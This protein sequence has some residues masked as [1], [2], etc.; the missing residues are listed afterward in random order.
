MHFFISI[1]LYMLLRKYLIGS[2]NCKLFIQKHLPFL[3]LIISYTKGVLNEHLLN[4]WKKKN[5]GTFFLF[6][7][8][9]YYIWHNIFLCRSWPHVMLNSPS[10]MTGSLGTWT[11]KLSTSEW[12]KQSMIGGVGSDVRTVQIRV[13][14]LG[15]LRGKKLNQNSLKASMFL[16]T[17]MVRKERKKRR[18]YHNC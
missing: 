1:A 15:S 5:N 16:L 11:S 3:F 8:W 10:S 2:W 6:D 12:L 13:M 18:S 7:T 17:S 9:A 4:D 14:D